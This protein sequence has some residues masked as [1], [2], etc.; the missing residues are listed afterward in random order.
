MSQD[1]PVLQYTLYNMY[2]SGVVVVLMD[3]KA[4]VSD[5]RVAGE[6]FP[7]A[8]IIHLHATEVL[9]VMILLKDLDVDSVL[10]EW[11]VKYLT[12]QPKMFFCS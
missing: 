8:G 1:Y 4:M 12:V 3:M 9:G 7:P 2:L 11:L 10:L 6:D 5:P